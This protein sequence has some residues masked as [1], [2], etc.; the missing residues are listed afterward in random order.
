MTFGDGQ[1]EHDPKQKN[2]WKTSLFTREVQFWLNFCKKRLMPTKHVTAISRS[3]CLLIFSIIS[4][5]TFDVERILA[6]Q[7]KKFTPHGHTSIILPSLITQLCLQTQGFLI[8][9]KARQEAKNKVMVEFFKEKKR[10]IFG[11]EKKICFSERKWKWKMN[12][13]VRVHTHI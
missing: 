9:E 8:N 11:R 10:R 7:L 13:I 1:L 6:W 5:K 12:E 2:K 4:H 3:M